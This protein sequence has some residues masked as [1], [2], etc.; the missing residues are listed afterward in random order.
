LRG[1][2]RRVAGRKVLPDR[3]AGRFALDDHEPP[4]LAQS[5]RRCK[6]REF[7]EAF[8]RVARQRIAAEA[9]HIAPPNQKI[10]ESCAEIVVEGDRC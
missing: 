8:D 10:A 1:K 9:P 6:A 3:G 5:H 7:D 2:C 4:R